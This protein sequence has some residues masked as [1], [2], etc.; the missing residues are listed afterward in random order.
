MHDVARGLDSRRR[1][2]HAT[3]LVVGSF[4]FVAAACSDGHPATAVPDLGLHG[5][6][7]GVSMTTSRGDVDPELVAQI[8]LT[9]RDGQVVLAADCNQAGS[10]FELRDGQL[11]TT[12]VTSTAIGCAAGTGSLDADLVDLLAAQPAVS[13]KAD[14]V[15]LTDGDVRL[16]VRPE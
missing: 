10:S 12:E 2:R 16:E 7:V 5:T 15:V 4:A 13:A 1:Y 14:G 11:Q 3:V 8:R 9:V 6:Y